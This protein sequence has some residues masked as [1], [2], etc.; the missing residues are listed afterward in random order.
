[1]S[2]VD[3]LIGDRVSGTAKVSNMSTLIVFPRPSKKTVL[4]IILTAEQFANCF[5]K[6]F[7]FSQKVASVNSLSELLNKTDC[8]KVENQILKFL[9]RTFNKLICPQV[10]QRS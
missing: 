1:M 10:G 7:A 8:F 6:S 4:S 3:R 5:S 2:F 9:L